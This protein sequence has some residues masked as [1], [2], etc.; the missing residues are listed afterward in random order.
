MWISFILLDTLIY[1]FHGITKAL[2]CVIGFSFD[3][4]TVAFPLNLLLLWLYTPREVGI[5]LS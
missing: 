3:V 1:S 4:Y 5:K 2:T